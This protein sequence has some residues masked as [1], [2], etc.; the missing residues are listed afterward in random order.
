M[1]D[2]GFASG[3]EMRKEHS[4][5]S[6]SKLHTA[7][8]ETRLGSMEVPLENVRSPASPG[9]PVTPHGFSRRGSLDL[10]DYFTGPRDMA[11][12]S[13]WPFFMQ[14]H[15][16]II[17]KMIMPLLFVAAWSTVIT[18]IHMEVHPIGVNSVLLTIT[19]FVISLGLS[20]RSSTAYERYAEGRRYWATLILTCQNLGRVFWIHA[21]DAN[22]DD[23]RLSMLKKISSMNL[24]V[25]FAISL[26]HR[27]RFE[28]YT[29]YPDMQHLVGHLNTFARAATTPDAKERIS[30][31]KTFF[32]EV[33]EYLGVS[34]AASNP[35][36]A[37]KQAQSPLG[38][39]PLEILNHLAITIDEMIVNKQ[40]EIPMQQTLAYNNLAML[41]DVLTGCD[42]V[43][44]TPLPIAYSIAIS[45]ITW[46]YVILLP[47]QLVLL[48][49][50]IAIPAT[51]G[52]AFIILGLLLIGREIENP[53]GTDVNDLPL[54]TYCDQIAADM[55]ITAAYEKR[56]PAAFFMDSNNMPLYPVSSAPLNV[57]MGRS[58]E[59]LRDAIK[60]KPKIT[61]QWRQT[62][63]NGGSHEKVHVGDDQV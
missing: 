29:A 2:G 21:R 6:P 45:Q 36:K 18:Y 8:E 48:L 35:R 7:I 14:M 61:F 56:N 32:K 47:F 28:P 15:G 59:R 3:G 9:I 44:N 5:P 55:D 22:T 24:L 58:E 51:V 40:L 57:W 10:D 54:E 26:K 53:F 49:N 43:L 41:N 11:K 20:F 16:S 52:A 30:R 33:G 37:L 46:V 39:M 23:P 38:N 19:G 17:P 27:L 42:R 31:K 50:W 4:P 34:F 63:D 62:K 60:S 12:H 13:K 1:A 25:A